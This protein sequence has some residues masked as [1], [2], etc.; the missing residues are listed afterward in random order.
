ME[1]VIMDR[2]RLGIFCLSAVLLCAANFAISPDV[3]AKPR[4]DR[5]SGSGNGRGRI[6]RIKENAPPTLSGTPDETVLQNSFYDFVPVAS[7]RD[8]DS[9]TFTIANK[10]DWADFDPTTGALYGTP[11]AAD[12]GHYGSIQIAASDGLATAELPVFAI[13]VVST[14]LAS[15]TLTWQPPTKNTDGTPL[16]DLAG[17]RIYYG[18]DPTNLSNV[19]ELPNPGLT[20]YVIEELTANTWHFAAT[21][22][23]E[24]GDE[25]DFSSL[26]TRDA[27]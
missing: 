6:K 1:R 27:R 23:N 22:L 20:S 18:V 10:P 25:S 9:L 24:R 5:V 12:V 15:V 3:S 8:G 4:L 17:Y 2:S 7:D 14:A 11:A 21:S 13:D 19:V 26:V 16:T